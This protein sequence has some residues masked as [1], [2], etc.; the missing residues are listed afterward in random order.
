VNFAGN[1]CIPAKWR[2]DR[3]IDRRFRRGARRWRSASRRRRARPRRGFGGLARGRAGSMGDQPRIP[4]QPTHRATRREAASCRA[5]D[6]V[7]PLKTNLME[8]AGCQSTSGL[9]RYTAPFG[10][11]SGRSNARDL[12]HYRRCGRSNC[13]CWGLFTVGAKGIQMT[14]PG[15]RQAPVDF[16]SD[17]GLCVVASP[18]RC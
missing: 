1:R 14:P 13:A 4:A 3:I 18:W 11:E 6:A 9:C 17:V 16:L 12:C 15:R 7:A 2:F 8:S 10:L 5:D